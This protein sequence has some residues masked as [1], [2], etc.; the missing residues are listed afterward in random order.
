MPQ[1]ESED[2]G[3]KILWFVIPGR[4]AELVEFLRGY[5][6]GGAE[7]ED[8]LIE[9]QEAGLVKIICKTRLSAGRVNEIISEITGTPSI[10]IN[11]EMNN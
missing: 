5:T 11:K 1:N 7:F 9:A 2:A 8:R 4:E 6:S 10:H 3:R